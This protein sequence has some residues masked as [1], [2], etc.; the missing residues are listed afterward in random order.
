MKI[1]N[2]IYAILLSASLGISSKKSMADRIK[3]A[4]P[5]SNTVSIKPDLDVAAPKK[6]ISVTDP[7]TKYLK[8]DAPYKPNGPLKTTTSATPSEKPD[9]SVKDSSANKHTDSDHHESKDILHSKPID[10]KEEIITPKEEWANNKLQLNFENASLQSV[11][12]DIGDLFDLVFIPDDSIH[13]GSNPN[14]AKGP[15]KS[16][17]PP[18]YG[19]PAKKG[20]G[21]LET[22]VTFRTHEAL[23]KDRALAVLDLFL[24]IAE[25]A[26]V[27]VPGMPD[28]YFRVTETK[29]ANRTSIPT[30]IGTDLND[31]PDTSL[32]RYLYF[33]TGTDV[34]SILNTIKEL[35]SNNAE[36]GIF[37]ESNALILTDHA[38]NIK[39]LMKIIK[40]IDNNGFPEILTIVK[41]KNSDASDAVEL[42]KSLQG[43]KPNASAN[44]YARGAGSSSSSNKSEDSY[45]SSSTKIIADN[46]TNSLIILGNKESV[47]RAEKFITE[48]IDK[49]LKEPPSLLHVEDLNWVT[50]KQMATILNNVVKYGKTPSGGAGKTGGAGEKFFSNLTFE[51]EPQGN[52]L[53]IRGKKEDYEL[54]K[55]IIRELD[56]KQPQVAIE[57]LIVSLALNKNKSLSTRMRTP[58]E[59]L[60]K[61]NFQTSPGFDEQPIQINETEGSH[62]KNSLVANLI[63]LATAAVNGST[64]LT[65][66]KTS[67]W[68]IMSILK[69]TTNSSIVSNPFLV[70][71][72]KYPA[73]VSLGSTRRITTGTIQG[74]LS[75]GN[76]QG[77]AEAN[78]SVTVTPQ[79]NTADHINMNIDIKIEDFTSSNTTDGNKSSKSIITNATVVDGEVLALGG[80]IRNKIEKV[81]TGVPILSKLP[82][83]GNLFK[84]RSDRVVKENLVIFLAPKILR[85]ENQSNQYT[86]IKS[87]LVKK[88]IMT[89]AF[90]IS[91]DP[92]QKYFFGD[93]ANDIDQMLSNIDPRGGK[94][95][96]KK[97][98]GASK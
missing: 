86:K 24:E 32:I 83:I 6:S 55:P 19:G 93:T 3:K 79:I 71:T 27:P 13:S 67:V 18:S 73:T 85:D 4:K 76:T 17:G 64:I 25:L 52:R 81:D 45:F 40:E 92:I 44:P 11:L 65:L 57:V 63:N 33:L 29:I 23:T 38:Y 95:K 7:A 91:S 66:G 22:K 41:L 47:Q 87:E 54:I 61:F 72:N 14:A 35:K 49:S 21:L 90:S 8:T 82:F 46:R 9:N 84:H 60:N 68:A 26:R 16:P 2:L 43:G 53:I 75:E 80:I 10:T 12:D 56:Q 28:N 88:P 69:T 37:Q 97:K 74:G 59:K 34:N 20:S 50:A 77:D 39:S 30:F 98:K 70:A 62:L 58:T 94:K 1:K 36:V 31:L 78:L 15:G 89:Q 48:Y 5:P 51:A 96:A 42:F